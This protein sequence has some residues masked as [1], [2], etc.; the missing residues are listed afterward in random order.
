M[1]EPS[2]LE[3]DELQEL[4]DLVQDG[5]RLVKAGPWRWG[6]LYLALVDANSALDAFA[7]GDE[8]DPNAAVPG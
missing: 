6:A 1:D 5:L 2:A 4:V 7:S 8:G 3:R